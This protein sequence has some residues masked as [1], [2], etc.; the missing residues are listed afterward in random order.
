[1]KIEWKKVKVTWTYWIIF[2]AS[3]AQNPLPPP[4][5][6]PGPRNNFFLIFFSVSPK[7][8]RSAQSTHPHRGWMDHLRNGGC[9]S[10]LILSIRRDVRAETSEKR[11]ACDRLPSYFCSFIVCVCDLR[12]NS[13]PGLAPM[14]RRGLVSCQRVVESKSFFSVCAFG[15]I[16]IGWAKEAGEGRG[17]SSLICICFGPRM[18]VFHT[19]TKRRKED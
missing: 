14:F 18:C 8:D 5:T 1:M 9:E 7:S 2:H 12:W 16:E 10:A 4:L 3:G 19:C 6:R 17:L 13:T 15:S 11:N